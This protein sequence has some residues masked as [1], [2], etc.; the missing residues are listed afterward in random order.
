MNRELIA[1]CTVQYDQQ[2]AGMVDALAFLAGEEIVTI[3]ADIHCRMHIG[4]APSRLSAH[5]EY[6]GLMA[7]LIAREQARESN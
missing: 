6:V 7:A 2:L 3:L 1:A 5:L 4:T